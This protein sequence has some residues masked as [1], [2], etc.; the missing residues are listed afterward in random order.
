TRTVYLSTAGETVSLNGGFLVTG[1]GSAPTRGFA[2][3]PTP[4]KKPRKMQI[5]GAFSQW[6]RAAPQPRVHPP[7]PLPPGPGPGTQFTSITAVVNVSATA[8]LG[9]HTITVQ[10]GSQ[11]LTARI[12][13][14]SVAAPPS[15]YISYMNPGLALVGQTLNVQIAGQYTH[16]LPGT[17]TI[18]FGAG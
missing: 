2:P 11:T 18:A 12:N 9:L 7:R 3:T 14:I 17:S 1:G 6:D 10:T 4:G 16:W 15:P 13:V 8:A 5:F